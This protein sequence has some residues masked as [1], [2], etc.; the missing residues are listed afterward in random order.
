LG[1][2]FRDRRAGRSGIFDS[3]GSSVRSHDLGHQS[4]SDAGAASLGREL[5]LEDPGAEIRRDPWAVV[6]DEDLPAGGFE[7]GAC[8]HRD[9]PARWG[10][11]DRI[12]D[13]RD[14]GLFE[15]TLV[16][17]GLVG[18]RGGIDGQDNGPG[19]GHGGEGRAEV[20]EER[21]DRG[22]LAAHLGWCG[23]LEE[24]TDPAFEL[25][26]GGKDSGLVLAQLGIGGE[27][28]AGELG[29]GADAGERVAEV[30]NDALDDLSDSGES[31][32]SD[33]LVLERRDGG[34][35]L[36]ELGRE[37]GEFVAPGDGHSVREVT[38]RDPVGARAETAHWLDDPAADQHERERGGGEYGEPGDSHDHEHEPLHPGAEVR[39]Q[40]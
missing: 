10:G 33:A 8:G 36:I 7:V 40:T 22:T 20:E 24:F 14:Q 38:V 4:K 25:I 5:G 11:L 34:G 30:M 19:L 26:D 6:S 9:R 32:A 27:L 31:L 17:V 29:E 39:S 23:A 2:A 28:I 15:V 3:Y 12:R 18:T 21:A 1:N 13:E 16:D 35:H 37:K